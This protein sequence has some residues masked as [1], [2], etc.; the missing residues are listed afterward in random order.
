MLC[1]LSS[2]QTNELIC[3]I[4]LIDGLTLTTVWP[5]TDWLDWT[6]IYHFYWLCPAVFL[7]VFILD[8]CEH[9]IHSSTA[10][11][12]AKGVCNQFKIQILCWAL[13]LCCDFCSVDN[14]FN[15]VW[16]ESCEFDI[17]NPEV[18]LMRFVV[19]DEDVFGEPNFLGQATIPVRSI[20]TGKA[21][22][23]C[24]LNILH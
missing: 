17:F 16:N 14:G 23:H 4:L 22:S 2:H 1:T 20:R 11:C 21:F 10:E 19:Q 7:V 15:P 8:S 3:R 9:A 13:V 12:F 24:V 6:N 5:P 18:A